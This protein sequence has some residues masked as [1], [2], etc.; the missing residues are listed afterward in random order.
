MKTYYVGLLRPL[1]ERWREQIP[2]VVN[3]RDK[4]PPRALFVK[5]VRA[6]DRAHAYFQLGLF[7]GKNDRIA[8]RLTARTRGS[9][10]KVAA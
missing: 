3:S 6:N 4:V 2:F 8:D 1:P 5:A 10:K 9:R 7:V